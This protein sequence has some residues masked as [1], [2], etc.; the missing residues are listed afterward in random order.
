MD[1]VFA[2]VLA[3]VLM[4]IAISMFL[5]GVIGLVRW[6]LG[7]SIWFMTRAD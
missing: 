1:D 7:K 6:S 5:F 3:S 2:L 4:I